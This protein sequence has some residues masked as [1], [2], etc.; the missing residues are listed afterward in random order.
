MGGLLNNSVKMENGYKL[1]GLAS[2][3]KHTVPYEGKQTNVGAV[4][5]YKSKVSDAQKAK[6]KAKAKQIKQAKKRNK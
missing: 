5:S 4:N 3:Q 6:A 2:Q 1:A